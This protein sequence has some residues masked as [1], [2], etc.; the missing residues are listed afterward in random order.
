MTSQE[1]I[2]IDTLL[3][4]NESLRQTVIR[5]GSENARIGAECE[6]HHKQL[7]V[8]QDYTARLAHLYVAS[9]HLQGTLTRQ[10]VLDAISEILINL[11]GSEDFGIYELENNEFTL[12]RGMGPGGQGRADRFRAGLLRRTAEAGQLLLGEPGSGMVAC[13]ALKVDGNVSGVIAIFSLLAHKSE[14]EPLDHE[15]FE[16]LATHAATALYSSTLQ[17]RLAQVSGNAR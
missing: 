8:L 2:S 9:Y 13:I 1:N 4:D 10:R 15:L 6:Q 17:S 12:A 3:S 7:V 5:L 14:L 16:L 11:I